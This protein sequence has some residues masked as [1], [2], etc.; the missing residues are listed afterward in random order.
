MLPFVGVGLQA[1]EKM[2]IVDKKGQGMVMRFCKLYKPEKI[3][4]II[5]VAQAYPWWRQNPTA[6]FMKAVGE[7]NRSE[8]ADAI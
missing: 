3:G 7:V 6:A 4:S 8:K 1:Q 2:E 5:E